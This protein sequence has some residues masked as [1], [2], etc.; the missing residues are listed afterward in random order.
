MALCTDS[1]DAIKRRYSESREDQD[2][3]LQTTYSE[4]LPFGRHNQRGYSRSGEGGNATNSFCN[5][6]LHD[7][8]VFR[9]STNSDFKGICCSKLCH[10]Y[11][12]TLHGI[13]ASLRQYIYIYIHL[14]VNTI[15]TTHHRTG[16]VQG[17]KTFLAPF[18]DNQTRNYNK[19]C[20]TRH[21]SQSTLRPTGLSNS[22]MKCELYT[23]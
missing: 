3:K 9:E 15:V 19:E 8:N 21:P 10:T 11:I 5:Y 16:D 7:V 13:W 22:K 20:L 4:N 6:D 18:A 14:S 1:S 12:F 23:I 2:K 17:Q